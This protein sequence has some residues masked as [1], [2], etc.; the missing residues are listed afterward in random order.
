MSVLNSAWI[1]VAQFPTQARESGYFLL[2]RLVMGQS[3]HFRILTSRP[4][5]RA[6]PP[7]LT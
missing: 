2:D 1:V 6:M 3:T 5:F 4:V 7:K